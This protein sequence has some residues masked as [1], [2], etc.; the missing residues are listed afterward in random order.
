M[1]ETVLGIARPQTEGPHHAWKAGSLGKVQAE[2]GV[3]DPQFSSTH[4]REL[5]QCI[6][7]RSLCTRGQLGALDQVRGRRSHIELFRFLALQLKQLGQVQTGQCHSIFCIDDGADVG[8]LLGQDVQQVAFRCRT[9][10]DQG[11]DTFHLTCSGTCIELG[12][13]KKF[14]LKEDIEVGG[15]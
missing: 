1:F 10:I 2:I 5:F 8:G 11:L 12:D 6:G 7:H 14:F 13:S 3:R 15:G 4:V 9:R